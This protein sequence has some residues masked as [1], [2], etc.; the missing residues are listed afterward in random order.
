VA[1]VDLDHPATAHV[2]RR[3]P[4]RLQRLVRGPTGPKAVRAVQE[5]LLVDGVQHHRD[6]PLKHFVFKGRDPERTRCPVSL[7]DFDAPDRRGVVRA[8]LEAVQQRPEVALQVRRIV[9]RRLLVYADRAILAR[10]LVGDA[11]KLHVD[12]MGQ[13][14]NGHLWGLPRQLCYPLQFR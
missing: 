13:R 6:R 3:V 8:G 12:V 7:R 9:R 2:H 11:E 4:Q 10:L 5:V 14:T 1:D